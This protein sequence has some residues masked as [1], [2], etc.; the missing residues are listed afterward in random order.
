VFRL[1]A[2]CLLFG[3]ALHTPQLP[4]RFV[5]IALQNRGQSRLLRTV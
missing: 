3:S 5:Q 2:A 1:G 4:P